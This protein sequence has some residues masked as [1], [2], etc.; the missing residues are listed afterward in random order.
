MFSRRIKQ[1]TPREGYDLWAQTYAH[2]ENPIKK[3]SDEL[4]TNWLGDVKDKTVLDVGCGAGKFCQL[5]HE[6]GAARIVGAD[7]SPKMIEE[8]RKNCKGAEL[9]LTDLTTETIKGQFDVVICALVLGHIWDLDFVLVN[10]VNNLTPD[11]VL[12]ITDFHPFQ[13]L[14]GAKRTF[15]DKKSKQSVE[16][17][18]HLHSFENYFRI[19]AG[20]N[21]FVGELVEPK[22]QDEPVVFGMKIRKHEK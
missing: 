19:L 10:L 2:E 6:K 9:E 7:L 5:V 3:Y 16:I 8:A 20:T 15:Q 14:K 12:L 18:H 4:I 13:T 17:K 11:G 21:A 22:W 1:L